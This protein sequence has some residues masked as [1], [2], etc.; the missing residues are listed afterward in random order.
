MAF[1]RAIRLQSSSSEAFNKSIS[2]SPKCCHYRPRQH[3]KNSHFVSAS[4]SSPPE[5]DTAT[6]TALS[7]PECIPQ[8]ASSIVDEAALE[9]IS[10]VEYLPI[11]TNL[12]QNPIKS[13]FVSKGSGPDSVI[14]INGFDSNILEYR[15][16]CKQFNSERATCYFF[17][18][19]GW[20]FTERPVDVG[21]GV[22]QK[23][24]HLRAFIEYVRETKGA[25]GKMILVGASI[26]A[27]VVVD[28]CLHYDGIDKLLLLDGQ[29]FLDRPSGLTIPGFAYLG[30]LVFAF[31]TGYDGLLLD[32]AMNRISFKSKDVLRIGGLHLNCPRWL[33][34]TIDFVRRPGYC[35]SEAALNLQVDT[36]VFVGR[37]RQ[38]VTE[39][40]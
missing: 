12:T 31:L 39:G 24:E 6:A 8:Q 9:M 14:F 19:L 27:A 40:F 23:R 16:V 15:Y 21:C 35:L 33:E 38:S 34:S 17:D 3:Q 10:A 1:V 20:G 25:S 2:A 28:Y 32:S 36:H 26:G 29:V 22:E 18:I 7:L 4:L 13:S 5:T 30:S 37:E 11:Q